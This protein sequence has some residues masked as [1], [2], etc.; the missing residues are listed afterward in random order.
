MTWSVLERA[1]WGTAQGGLLEAPVPGLV[2]PPPADRRLGVR[3]TTVPTQDDTAASLVADA[4]W[5][6]LGAHGGAGV[7]S[8]RRCGVSGLDA[9]RLWPLHGR[10]V[11]VAR[12]TASSLEWARDAARQ[13]AAG[14]TSDG[15]T[16]TGLAVVADAPGRCPA[17]LEQFLSLVSGAFARTWEVPWVEEWRLAGHA[18]SMPM[19]PAA[20]QLNDDMQRLV[21][22][23]EP[24]EEE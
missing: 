11:V 8:L 2:T 12:R 4:A 18:E 13:H 15:V 20:K 5:W 1:G 14:C 21:S 19:P 16:L 3:T 24:R 9:E 7:T 17:R 22:V 6:L 10:V 23:C